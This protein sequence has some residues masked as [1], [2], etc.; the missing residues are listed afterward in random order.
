MIDLLIKDAVIVTVNP[1]R[2]ILWNGALAIRGGRILEIGDSAHVCGRYPEAADVIDA[3][4]KVVFPGLINTHNHLFQTLLKGLGDDMALS[5]WCATMT[6]PS[7]AHLTEEDCYVA[8]MLGCLEGLHSGITTMLDYMYPHPRPGLS[9]AVIRAFQDLRLRGVFARGSM[10]AGGQ[11]GVPEFIR[12]DPATVEA[13]CRRLLKTYHGAEDGR[14]RVWVAPAAMLANSRDLLG[15]LWG[16]AQEYQTGFT[17]HISETPFDREAARQL[18]GQVDAELLQSLG[19]VGPNVLLVHCVHL[20]ERD[21]RMVKQ[22]D[23]KISHNTVSNMY[24]S[25]GVAPVPRMVEAGITVSLGVDGAASNNSQDMIELMKCTALLHKAH[26]MDP[27]VITAEKVLEMATI[28]GARALGL[29]DEVGSLEAGKKADLFIFNP[30]ASAKSVPMHNPVSTLVY[31]ASEANVETVV[32]DGRT[33]VRD[34]K[35]V[36]V[37]EGKFLA[38]AQGAAEDLAARAGIRNRGAG[39]PWRS[40]AF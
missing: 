39:H 28:D 1:R 35:V 24:L 8:A 22:Y 4:G 19:I 31:S 32:V 26:T 5:D 10:D 2:E 36:A 25:S 34:S 20:T 33:L 23:M 7:A 18:H 40:L 30:A 21:I 12:Q 15:R 37:D 38:R 27:T 3:S 11:F 16:L 17:V 13:D 9:D 29:E 6:F 14:L